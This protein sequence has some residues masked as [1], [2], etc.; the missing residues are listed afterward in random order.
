MKLFLK[1]HILFAVCALL[2]A[3]ASVALYVQNLVQL[4]HGGP[5]DPARRP[6]LPP[7]MTGVPH[8]HQGDPSF[9][10]PWMTFE[11][12]NTSFSIP[13]SYFKEQYAITDP[14]YPHM[15]LD[16]EARLLQ[17]NPRE[18]LD[19]VTSKIL[20]FTHTKHQSE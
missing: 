17:R 5:L 7:P 1:R 12:I 2:F 10:K 8:R 18:F 11:Y 13:P 9:V 15:T 20:E 16:A 4:Y 19:D 14:T 3:A 6:P